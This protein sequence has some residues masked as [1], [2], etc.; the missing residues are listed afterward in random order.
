MLDQTLLKDPARKGKGRKSSLATYSDYLR[1][2][3]DQ[4]GEAQHVPAASAGSAPESS[5]GAPSSSNHG[6]S[7]LTPAAGSPASTGGAPETDGVH[8]ET[9]AEPA[10]SFL[11]AAVKAPLRPTQQQQVRS[12][13]S[14]PLSFPL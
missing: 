6:P 5:Q 9:A 2:K 4:K 12:I 13:S 1:A 8:E 3:T 11:A 14:T 7:Q 10:Q